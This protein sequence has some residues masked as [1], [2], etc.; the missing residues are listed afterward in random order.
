[1]KAETP[2]GAVLVV[3]AGIGGIQSSLELADAGFKVYLLDEQP[4]IGGVMSMLDKTFPTNDCSMCI[5]SPKLVGTGRHQNIELLT[6]SQLLE[7]E[8]EPGRFKA[9][10]RRKARYVDLDKCTG[11]GDCAKVC[12]VEVPDSYNQGISSRRATFR[13]FPQAIP[14][15][16]TIEKNEGR[17]PCRLACPA[18]V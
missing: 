9:R 17:A 6:W 12:P 5:L 16:F 11:C 18:G 3:G 4:S 7:L 10:I 1:M 15:A 14:N 13:L 2:V 8:G